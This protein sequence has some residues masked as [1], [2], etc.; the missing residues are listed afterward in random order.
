VGGDRFRDPAIRGRGCGGAVSPL[1]LAAIGIY[2][3]MVFRGLR[4]RTEGESDITH[5]QVGA[6]GSGK[7]FFW[8]LN[9]KKRR[10][11]AACGF[12][13]DW[14]WDLGRNLLCRG[15]AMRSVFFCI[16]KRDL[17]LASVGAVAVDALDGRAILACYLPQRGGKRAIDPMAALALRK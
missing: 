11:A 17:M 4:R 7:C 14:F 1:V 8:L 9:G 5:G 13:R 16:S 12:G 15:A 6:Q 2:G 10:H 3:V